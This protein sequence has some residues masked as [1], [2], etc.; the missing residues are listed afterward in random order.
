MKETERKQDE[1][2][3]VSKNVNKNVGFDF[4]LRFKYRRENRELRKSKA[5]AGKKNKQHPHPIL[6]TFK[7]NAQIHQLM[8]SQQ[9]IDQHIIVMMNLGLNH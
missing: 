7:T 8:H 6:T 5:G 9:K 2:P 3:R 4:H 1:K